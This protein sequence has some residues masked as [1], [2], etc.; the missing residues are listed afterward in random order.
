MKLIS[1]NME[2]DK[3][4]DRVTPFLVREDADVICLQEAPDHYISQLE[5]M[6]Y[7]VSFLARVKKNYGNG[8]FVD[9]EVIATKTPHVKEEFI[10]YKPS[11]QLEV[12]VPAKR[13]STN[14]Q[15]ALIGRFNC[16]GSEYTVATTHF[17][18]SVFDGETPDDNQRIDMQTLLGHTA[19]LEPHVLCGDFN[20]PRHKN[21]LYD[22]LIEQY[23]DQIPPDHITSMDKNI[24]R[25][26]QD[27]D[28]QFIFEYMVDYVFTK[29]PYTANDVRL[30]FGVSDHAAVVATITQQWPT[31]RDSLDG[32]HWYLFAHQCDMPIVVV[33]S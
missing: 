29:P 17:T 26:G 8:E 22:Q 16:G 27:P 18:I 24:H 9:G 31:L 5:A 20:I 19:K 2:G 25:L 14:R 32:R 13:R 30:E 1:L 33:E 21:E 4:F 15:V 3:H 23:T 11:D 12:E 28:K 6:G 10:Y 7:H